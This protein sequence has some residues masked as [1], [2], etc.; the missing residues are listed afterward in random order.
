MAAVFTWEETNG[1]TGSPTFTTPTHFNWKSI[2]DG[3]AGT[4]YTASPIVAGNNSFQKYLAG[5]FTGTYNNLLAGLWAHTSN[6]AGGFDGTTIIIFG[7]PACTGDA[8]RTQFATP[9][10]TNS[11]AFATPWTDMSGTTAIGSGRAV[12]F[13]PTSATATGKVSTVGSAA[14]WTSYMGTQ[15]K[16]TGS[17]AAGDTDTATITFQ[18]QEN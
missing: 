17:A 16:T 6:A 14:A 15:L 5:K 11:G 4:A 13:G 18:Y 7:S 9:D 10:A 2:A 1:T 8:N 3:S 12:F